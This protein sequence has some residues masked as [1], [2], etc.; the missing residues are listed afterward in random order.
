MKSRGEL[1][2]THL[3]FSLNQLGQGVLCS[4]NFS[5][6]LDEGLRLGFS[7]RILAS[8][9]KTLNFMTS[10]KKEEEQEKGEEGGGS[11]KENPDTEKFRN[12]RTVTKSDT[13]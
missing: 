3:C 13:I 4:C 12:V 2:I 6:C 7:D 9:C 5:K 10:T 11:N 8:L 1:S